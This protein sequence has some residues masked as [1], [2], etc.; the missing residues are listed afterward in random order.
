[1]RNETLVF[2]AEAENTT[3]AVRKPTETLKEKETGKLLA[4]FSVSQNP[5]FEELVGEY[6]E[7]YSQYGQTKNGKLKIERSDDPS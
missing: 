6:I 2:S 1:M 3:G 4:S 5:F 7:S